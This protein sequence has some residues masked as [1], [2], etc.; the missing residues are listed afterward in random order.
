MG[1]WPSARL[2][3]WNMLIRP[4][5][6]EDALAVARL[7]VRSWQAAYR[8]LLLDDYLDQLR[9]ED[10]AARYDFSHSDPQKP[11]TQVA[12]SKG[13]IVGF[14]TNTP[15]RDPDCTGLGELLA[16][17]VAQEQ[18]GLGVGRQLAASARHRLIERGFTEAV[19]WMLEGNARADRFYRKEGWLPDG[20]HRC[21]EIWG[22][23][24]SELRYRRVLIPN[25]CSPVPSFPALTT[26]AS[27]AV[28]SPACAKP[29]RSAP[30]AAPRYSRLPP[31]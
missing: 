10:R 21:D 8:S 19:L 24:L 6:P 26:P 31:A 9:P 3:D 13:Q 15:A 28:P 2:Y 23:A 7:H 14:A 25:P 20:N 27:P 16:L 4:A 5:Q 12:E 1:G 11:Y 17:H 22:I 30:R 18:W 29:P